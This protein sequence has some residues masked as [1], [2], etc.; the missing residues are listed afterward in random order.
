MTLTTIKKGLK[1]ENETKAPV[2]QTEK[3][4][5][6]S[7]KNNEQVA[8]ESYQKVLKEKRNYQAKLEDYELK[9]QE[10][11]EEKLS[12]EGKKDELI[13][14]YRKQLSEYK[15]NLEKT[16]QN[17]AWSSLTK[18]VEL[19][20]KSRNC[21]NTS[22]LIR[23]MDKEDFKA[24]EMNEDY[25]INTE[26]LKTVLDKTMKENPFLFNSNIKFSANGNPS[27]KP[28]E[29]KKLDIKNL[30]DEEIKERYKQLF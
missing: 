5:G 29:E 18:A 22:K 23:L 12:A 10:L 2:E 24:I 30:S 1:M 14:T 17:F 9:L 11:Q 26:S 3:T 16:K 6:D 21:T 19:E 4:S 15:D 13:D 25:S 28:V 7:V 20:A 8:Y 27:S